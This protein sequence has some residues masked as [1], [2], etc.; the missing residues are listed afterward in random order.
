MTLSGRSP[1]KRVDEAGRAYAG[2]QLQ[3]QIYVNRRRQEIDRA[4]ISALRLG[5]RQLEWVSPLEA[6]GFKEYHDDEFLRQLGCEYL[7]GDL[8]EFWPA[9]GPRWDGLAMAPLVA[10]RPVILVEAKSYPREVLG[11]GCKATDEV[12]AVK[13]RTR[14]ANALKA[15]AAYLGVTD[16]DHVADDSHWMGPLYQYANRLAHAVFLRKQGLDA[17]MV[18][19]CFTDDPHRPTTEAEWQKVCTSLT[20]QLGLPYR[21]DWLADVTLPARDRSELL[22]I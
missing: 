17:Y 21:P 8:R 6:R 9:S 22:S 3:L 10:A 4:I 18:N 2:S 7:S 11:G 12:R 14:I 1:R 15:T 16:P 13:A 20:G 5:Q 19:V